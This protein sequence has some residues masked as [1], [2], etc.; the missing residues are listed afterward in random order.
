MVWVAN[1]LSVTVTHV[2][3]TQ[4]S[5]II[6]VQKHNDALIQKRH[7]NWRYSASTCIW[8]HGCFRSKS[9]FLHPTKELKHKTKTWNMMLSRFSILSSKFPIKT[10]SLLV[11]PS[12]KPLWIWIV[13]VDGSAL[14]PSAP[15]PCCV[16]QG[17]S[18]RKNLQ[19]GGWLDTKACNK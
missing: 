15:W 16:S 3:Q 8:L 10:C 7:Q 9:S 14:S 5:C 4:V 1:N 2:K 18:V 11:F 13:P 6:T 19:A 17:L 12:S